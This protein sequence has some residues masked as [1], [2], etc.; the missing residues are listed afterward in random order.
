MNNYKTDI[1]DI[2]NEHS[3]TPIDINMFRSMDKNSKLKYL[4]LKNHP[5]AKKWNKQTLEII[6]LEYQ[7]LDFQRKINLILSYLN[8]LLESWGKESIKELED[9]K[10]IDKQ[11][12]FGETSK[13]IFETYLDEF[14]VIFGKN[15]ISYSRRKKI[16][17]YILTVTKKI[18]ELCGYKLDFT[19]CIQF[20]NIDNKNIRISKSLVTILKAQ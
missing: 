8:E 3:V 19:T 4:E 7:I 10:N 6:F 17:N 16:N 20:K 13:N 11:Y 12:F 1:V 5:H 15:Q 2:T 9:F 18:L 14:C